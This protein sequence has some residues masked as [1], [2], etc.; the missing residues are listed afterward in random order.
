MRRL[1]V[2][3]I[4][5]TLT[6]TN[7]V[8][9]ECYLQAISDTL[10]FERQSLD[11]SDAPHVTDAALLRWFA[12]RQHFDLEPR[13]ETAVLGRFIELLQHH[14]EHSPDRFRP[15]PGA[16]TVRAALERH[17]WQV[18]LATGGWE[19]SARLKLTAIGFDPAG[20]VLA[21]AHD[22]ETRNG[23][24]QLAIRH[25]TERHGSFDQV[26]SIGDGVWDVRTAREMG[27]PFIGVAA[28]RA[29]DR[30]RVAGAS[31]ILPD[32]SDASVLC[33]SLEYATV[34]LPGRQNSSHGA[35]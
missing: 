33:A 20:L 17:G 7:V 25:A 4:D 11:W 22:S 8:D 13:H 24:V 34:P 27:L 6:D 31:I 30:L 15:I 3:D 2:F 14:L 12:H 16:A 18:A 10:G 32:L 19:E 35:P 23:I 26:V 21:T 1:A 29:A 28:E 5:G 9:D